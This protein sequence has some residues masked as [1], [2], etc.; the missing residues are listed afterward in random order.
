M[1]KCADGFLHTDLW[2]FHLLVWHCVV[3]HNICNYIIHYSTAVWNSHCQLDQWTKHFALFRVLHYNEYT[4]QYYYAHI[5]TVKVQW[6]FNKCRLYFYPLFA[7]FKKKKI[8]S[9]TCYR[10][11]NRPWHFDIHTSLGLIYLMWNCISTEHF[12]HSQ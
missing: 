11:I 12:K 2:P 10:G 5:I 4:P 3:L 7:L 1:F 8:I 9:R 6:L